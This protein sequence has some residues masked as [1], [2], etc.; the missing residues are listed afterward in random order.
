MPMASKY[1]GVVITGNTTGFGSFGPNA[2]PPSALK[3]QPECPPSGGADAAP[4]DLTGMLRNLST[5]FRKNVTCCSDF[6]YLA[7]G[8]EI[9]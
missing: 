1:P 2:R 7:S 5:K 6:A 4:A 9:R 3:N 8:S